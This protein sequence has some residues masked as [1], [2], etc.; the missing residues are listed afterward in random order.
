MNMKPETLNS[1]V[2][3]FDLNY[4]NVHMY[5]KK[6]ISQDLRFNNMGKDLI[7]WEDKEYELKYIENMKNLIIFFKKQRWENYY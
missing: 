6:I 1:L 4:L 7:F 3:A 5:N 2:K